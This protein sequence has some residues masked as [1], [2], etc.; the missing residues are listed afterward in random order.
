MSQTIRRRGRFRVLDP[1]QTTRSANTRAASP[2][3]HQPGH[4]PEL[5]T[6]ASRAQHAGAFSRVIVRC[7]GKDGTCWHAGSAVFMTDA[8][9]SR[10]DPRTSTHCPPTSDPTS[11]RWC[12]PGPADQLRPAPPD[13]RQDQNR[14]TIALGARLTAA[15]TKTGSGRHPIWAESALLLPTAGE[16][17]EKPRLWWPAGDTGHLET[18]APVCM[19]NSVPVLTVWT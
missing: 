1:R 9:T 8:V 6:S 11:S 13:T 7:P 2:S 19:W 12:R 10:R 3:H 5:W 15:T 4:L 14:E 18:G 16:T 17:Q